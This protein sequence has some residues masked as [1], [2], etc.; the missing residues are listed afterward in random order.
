MLQGYSQFSQTL[1]KGLAVQWFINK[2][3]C[4]TAEFE[5]SDDIIKLMRET[6]SQCVWEKSWGAHGKIVS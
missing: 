3:S 4:A 2:L 5:K 1:Y 6:V